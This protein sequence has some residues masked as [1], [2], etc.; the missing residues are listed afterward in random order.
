M[1]KLR[2]SGSQYAALRQHLFPGDDNEAIAFALCGRHRHEDEETLLVYRLE[3]FP[4]DKCLVRKPDLIVWPPTAIVHLLEEC[5]L[6]GWRLLKIHCHPGGGYPEFSEVDDES[7]LELSDTLTGWTNRDEAFTS[8]IMLPGGH[9]FGRVVEADGR[10]VPLT[11]VLVAGDDIHLFLPANRPGLE[12]DDDESGEVQLRTRQAFGLGTTR[13][14]RGLRVG[15]VG[16]SGT[17]SIVAE[18]LGRLGV[19]ELVLVDH[20]RV[21]FK[22]LNRILNTRSTDAETS[23]YKVEVLKEALEASGTGVQ[24]SAHPYG[25]HDY[26]AYQAIAGCDVVFGCMDSVDGRHLLNRIATFFTQPYFDIGV[27]LDADGT[28]GID[29]AMGRVDYLQPGGSSLLSRERYTLALL[30]AADLARINPPEY[31]RQLAEKYIRSAQVESPAVISIN[32]SFAAQAVTELLAR[33]HPFRTEGNGRFAEVTF[34]IAGF[35]LERQREGT[36]DAEL[37]RYVGRGTM[38]PLLNAP[39]LI[40]NKPVGA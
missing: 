20:D 40:T 31:K 8:A 1:Y 17:G 19:G 4:H 10:F 23:R 33:L 2:M 38:R 13:Q 9:I 6:N 26:D 5:R 11:S 7:D 21:E 30:Q 28:G 32:M 34:S 18:L 27:R 39:L 25:L 12:A 24:V 36:P 37:A 29:E 15:V 3:L 14:L 16:C 35:L 22:N